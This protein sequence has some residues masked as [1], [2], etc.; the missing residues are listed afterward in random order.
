MRTRFVVPF[1]VTFALGGKFLYHQH[2][3][4][5]FDSGSFI[6]DSTDDA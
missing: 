6:N 3:L 5:W 1:L 4:K 2:H